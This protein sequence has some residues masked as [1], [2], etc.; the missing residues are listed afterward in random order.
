M[1]NEK[2]SI[3][4]LFFYSF[5][6]VTNIHE[7]GVHLV[8]RISSLNSGNTNSIFGTPNINLKDKD[9]YTKYI[10]ERVKEF[11]ES[12]EIA[13]FGRRIRELTIKEA[14]FIIDPYNYIHGVNYFTENFKLCNSKDN[15]DIISP[16]TKLFLK[17]L[18]I[19]FDELPN[20]SL[21]KF[22]FSHYKN[23]DDS[24]TTFEQEL[25]HRL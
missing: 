20:N 19:K 6:I 22:K 15:I 1:K 13:L 21:K 24:D 8:I 10:Q 9:L 3:A 4:L 2:K 18:D 14:L 7:I 12:L 25:I 23:L 17:Q 5:N 16:K 11:G